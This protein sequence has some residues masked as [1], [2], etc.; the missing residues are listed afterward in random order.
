MLSKNSLKETAL[1]ILA[2]GLTY[3][4]LAP[5]AYAQLQVTPGDIGF[6]IPS[7]SSFLGLII[8]LFF[9]IAGLAALFMLLL[10]AFAWITSGGSKEN[11]E[12]ARDKMVAGFVGVILIIFVLIVMVFLEQVVFGGNLCFGISCPLQLP[13]QL[14]PDP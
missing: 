13:Q 7:P 1:K 9:I 4:M 5:M 8:R 11:I 2:T 10:G 14:L 3:A 12:K 6:S